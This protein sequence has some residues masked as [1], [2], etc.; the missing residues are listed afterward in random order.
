[1][2]DLVA[3]IDEQNRNDW[4]SPPPRLATPKCPQDRPTESIQHRGQHV[5][6]PAQ[7]TLHDEPVNLAEHPR[8]DGDAIGA[9]TISMDETLRKYIPED[10]ELVTSIKERKSRLWMIDES[11][12]KFSEDEPQFDQVNLS[13]LANVDTVLLI[14]DINLDWCEKLCAKYPDA[15]SPQ[16]LAEHIIRFDQLPTIHGSPQSLPVYKGLLASLYSTSKIM[17]EAEF[18]GDLVSLEVMGGGPESEKYGFHLDVAIEAPSSDNKR[19]IRGLEY[20]PPRSNLR[21]DIFSR[22]TSNIWRRAS[23]R[24]SCVQLEATLCKAED[25]TCLDIDDTDHRP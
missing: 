22:D 18:S 14:Q 1:M 7:P 13:R 11:G 4:T 2:E 12:L 10:A 6:T 20:F 8:Q 5:V 23:S 17:V 21:R 16:I 19:N 15:L 3:S 9:T 25:P 24:M